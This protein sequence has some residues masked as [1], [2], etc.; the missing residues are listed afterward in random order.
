M[1]DLAKSFPKP[2]IGCTESAQIEMT[3][4]RPDMSKLFSI[5]PGV[6]SRVNA[7]NKSLISINGAKL[8]LY[9]SSDYDLVCLILKA[10][11]LQKSDA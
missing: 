7:S 10:L 9:A 3:R 6:V 5:D 1:K 11:T 4:S 2:R 8:L